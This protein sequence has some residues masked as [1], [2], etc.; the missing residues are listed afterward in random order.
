MRARLLFVIALIMAPLAGALDTFTTLPEASPDGEQPVTVHGFMGGV[1]ALDGNTTSVQP[2]VYLAVD[3]PTADNVFAPHLIVN[4]A[5]TAEPGDSVQLENPATWKAMEF[6]MGFA[7]P[8]ST[9]V[10]F[11]LYGE[12]GFATKLPGQTEPLVKTARWASGGL[13]FRSTRGMM[14]VGIGADQRLTGQYRPAVTITGAVALWE[15]KPDKEGHKT[16]GGAKLMLVG[17]AVLGLDAPGS[18]GSVKTRDVVRVGIAA[19]I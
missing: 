13:R 15:A 8:V 3:A 6:S 12:L 10:H 16:L 4:A 7:Q 19:G 11:D 1:T 14:A 9:G 18:I 5:L 17:S 2:F